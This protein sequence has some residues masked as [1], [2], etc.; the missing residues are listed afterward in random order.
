M[1]KAAFLLRQGEMSV[2]NISEAVG[3]ANLSS[4]Y[5]TFQKY[6]GL[7]PT[8]WLHTSGEGKNR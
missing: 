6:Y 2:Q 8:A 5:R 7:P 4:F 1:E 3:Y